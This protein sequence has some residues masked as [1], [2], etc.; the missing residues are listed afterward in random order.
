MAAPG[1]SFVN[2]T[3]LGKNLGV[4]PLVTLIEEFPWDVD[5]RGIPREAISSF[6]HSLFQNHKLKGSCSFLSSFEVPD[7]RKSYS[8]CLVLTVRRQ[9]C[10][11]SSIALD[12]RLSLCWFL[13]SDCNIFRNFYQPECRQR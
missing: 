10:L 1:S 11:I 8:I 5:P 9:R 13:V 2:C 3:A 12:R 6:S 4:R 7:S